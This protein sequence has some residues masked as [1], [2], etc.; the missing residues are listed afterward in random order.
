MI[1]M[2]DKDKRI[3]K[4]TREISIATNINDKIQLFFLLKKRKQQ[5]VRQLLLTLHVNWF[6]TKWKI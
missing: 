2:V 6:K 5:S 4:E 1:T 3:Y